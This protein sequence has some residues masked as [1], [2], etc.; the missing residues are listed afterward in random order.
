MAE[1]SDDLLSRGPKNAAVTLELFAD[2]QSPVSRPTIDVLDQLMKKYPTV[3]RLQ[4]R[5]Y[6]L[7]F[8][9]QAALAHEA[10][11]TAARQGQFW[12]FASFILGHQDSLREQDLII[13]AGRLGLDEAA[14]AEYVEAELKAQRVNQP[15]TP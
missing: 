2:L 6:P 12:P 4:F 8:H 15:T 10:A 7:A 13:Y 11:M 14:F 1:I 9:A 5:N 3:V